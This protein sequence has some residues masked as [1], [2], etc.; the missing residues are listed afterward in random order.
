MTDEEVDLLWED[1]V[2][3]VKK[4]FVGFGDPK[5][6]TKLWEKFKKERGE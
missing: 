4:Q 5:S 3:Y 6:N 2:A 1:F